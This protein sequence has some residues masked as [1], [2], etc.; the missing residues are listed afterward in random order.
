MDSF[1]NSVKSLFSTY[2]FKAAAIVVATVVIVNLIKKPL[3]AYARKRAAMLKTD[4]S[5]VTKYVTVLP[6][7]V[8]FVLTFCVELVIARFE[9]CAIDWSDLSASALLYSA[10]AVALYESVKKQFEAYA[11]ECNAEGGSKS[12]DSDDCEGGGESAETDESGESL[13]SN[14]KES[15]DGGADNGSSVRFSTNGGD[16]F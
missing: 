12:C 2:G 5:I 10:L 15:E 11:A 1:I 9:I 3:M 14:G 13:E 4:K 7:V 16:G 6:I 8:S